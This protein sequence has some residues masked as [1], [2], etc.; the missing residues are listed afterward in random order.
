VGLASAL[1]CGVAAA[2]T[3]APQG[4]LHEEDQREVMRFK[5]GQADRVVAL[6]MSGAPIDLPKPGTALLALLGGLAFA[7]SGRQRRRF[8]PLQPA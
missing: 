3:E 6:H 7:A 1:V 4:R 2:S 5:P 8:A